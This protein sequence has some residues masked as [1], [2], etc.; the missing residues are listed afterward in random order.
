MSMNS[1]KTQIEQSRKSQD[2]AGGHHDSSNMMV[3]RRG[4]ERYVFVQGSCTSTLSVLGENGLFSSL[5][6]RTNAAHTLGARRQG[7][8]IS[9][10]T[11]HEDEATYGS[12]KPCGDESSA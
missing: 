9:R 6:K 11:L 7:N 2:E 8:M 4:S 3:R 5:A 1:L 12:A 10:V